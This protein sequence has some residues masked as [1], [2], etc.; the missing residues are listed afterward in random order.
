MRDPVSDETLSR[1]NSKSVLAKK[2]PTAPPM[3]TKPV[4]PDDRQIMR[5]E[6]ISCVTV[7]PRQSSSRRDRRNGHPIV[8]V[9]LSRLSRY[10]MI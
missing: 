3:S 10:R 7:A 6:N 5:H 8:A 9:F 2:M 1:L 4:V